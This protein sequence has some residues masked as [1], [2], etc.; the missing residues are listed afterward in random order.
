MF[1]CV[2]GKVFEEKISGV[3]HQSTC[4]VYREEHKRKKKVVEYR[5][6]E[7]DHVVCKVCG[8]KARD[9]GAHF[10]YARSPH[11]NLK[12]Y[13]EKYPDARIACADVENKRKKTN[14]KRHGDP[15]YRNSDAQS[16]SIRKAMSNPSV[17]KRIR[18]TK[19]ERYGDPGFVNVE[20]RK[21]TLLKKYGV[22]NAMKDPCIAMKAVKTSTVLYGDDYMEKIQAMRKTKGKELTAEVLKELVKQ[23]L[24]DEA[25][26]KMYGLSGVTV[27][28]RRD[29]YL[30][31]PG[32]EYC[33]EKRRRDI[34]KAVELFKKVS[35]TR[36]TTRKV[37]RDKA[38]LGVASHVLEHYYGS[39]GAFVSAC[40]IKSKR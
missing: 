27:G 21:K 6:E 18:K 9:L 3:R 2:C 26:G 39:W 10:R 22:D 20:A 30:I 34:Q 1:T 35:V 29:K 11:I 19:K 40:G 16:A 28:S 15:N 25:I 36:G 33:N 32:K 17:M 4:M 38:L 37:Y 8:Y 13:R 24:S 14:K 7:V 31:K 5:E 23:G 12:E